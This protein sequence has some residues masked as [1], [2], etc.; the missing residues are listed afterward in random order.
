MTGILVGFPA[1]NEERTVADLVRRTLAV[2]ELAR[3]IHCV[4]VD[5]GST[6]ATAAEAAAAGAD[7]I[8]PPAGRHGL[9]AGVSTILAEGVARNADVVA[10]MDADGEYRPEDLPSLV[11]PVLAGSA[12]YV[13]GNRFASGRPQGMPAW[14]Q[15][16]NRAGSRLVGL[17]TGHRI[18]DAQ[19][20]IRALS[21][22]AAAAA[23]VPHDYNYS[24]VLTLGLLRQGYRMAEVPCGYE[25]RHH[26][27]TFV[28]LHV[29]VPRV[30]L[31]MGRARWGRRPL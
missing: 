17:V 18:R 11:A 16:G 14:R 10:F 15:I 7:V 13:T 23:W 20:G 3:P 22:G 12:D 6:D 21:R 30:L 2:Q 29:Y 8:V 1:R 24:Q 27:R 5:D 31:A 4:V 9:G 19:S 28:R 25:R 26:G